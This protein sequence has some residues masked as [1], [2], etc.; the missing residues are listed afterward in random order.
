MSRTLAS[1]SHR[2]SSDG[3][4]YLNEVEKPGENLT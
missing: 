4:L 2:R 1:D 3:E